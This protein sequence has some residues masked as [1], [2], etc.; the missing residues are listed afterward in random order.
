MQGRARFNYLHNFVYAGETTG[1][2][3]K[4]IFRYVLWLF[5]VAAWPHERAKAQS[6]GAGPSD[7]WGPRPEMVRHPFSEEDRKRFLE[8]PSLY[9]PETWFHFI[10]GNVSKAGITADLEAIREAGIRGIQLFHG[11]FGGEWPGVSPQVK[12][13]TAPWDDMIHHVAQEC[14]R[15]DLRFTMQNCPG[16][17]MAGG[18]WITPENAMRHLV[19]SRTD[20]QGGS[21]QT[22]VLPPPLSGG[23]P[24]RDYREVAVIA[25]PTP[26]GDSVTPLIPRSVTSNLDHLPWE[27]NLGSPEGAKIVLKG[28]EGPVWVEMDFGSEITLRR[29]QFPSI[30]SFNHSWCYEPGVTVKIEAILPQKVAEV[31]RM[32]LPQS[33]W[34]DN[35]PFTMACAEVP[36]RK[37]RIT[38]DNL[39]DMIFS[40]I[41]CFTGARMNNWEAQAGWTLR[42]LDRGSYPEQS[43]NTW[44]DPREV[45]NLT[46]RMD[47]K[48][49]LSW[50]VPAGQWTVMRVGHVNTGKKNG[51]AP[52]EATGWEC[53][54]LSPEGA[55]AH[56]AGYIGRLS[57]HDGPVGNGLMQ[58]MLL[59][60]WE[61]ETQTWTEGMDARFQELRGYSLWSW[62]PALMGYTVGAPE[63]T[64]RFLRDWRATLNDLLVKNFYGRMV[65]LGHQNGLAV[66]YETASGDVFPADILEY[67]KYADVPMC[68]FWH[69]RSEGY[70]GSMNF[71]PIK[72]A[73]SAARLYGKPRLAAE[74]FTSFN[75]TYHESPAMLRHIA[76]IHFAEGVSHL[77]FHTYTH[78]P[79]TDWL[80]P[81][82]SFGSGIGTPFLRGQTWWRYMKSFTTSL[83]RCTY[84]LER[85]Q[86]V[87]DVLW[88]LGDELDHKPLQDAPFPEGYH[89]DYCNTDVLLNR[90]SV[91]D[92]WIVTPEGIRYRLLWLKDSPRLLTE[93]LEK[94]KTMLEQG[95]T[96]VG[97][98]PRGM[99]TLTGGKKAAERYKKLVSHL[100][101]TD[102]RPGVRNIGKGHLISGVSLEAALLQSGV[103][104]DVQGNGLLWTHRG[105]GDADWYFVTSS[106]EEGYSGMP[107]FRAAGTVEIWDPVTG[108]M[109]LAQ[110]VREEKGFTGVP[111]ELPPSGAC[112]ILFRQGE[113]PGGPTGSGSTATRVV[114][115]MAIEGPWT[116]SFPSGWDA[117][118]SLPL[119]ELKPWTMLDLPP[120][121]KSFSGT[122][123][124]S[125]AFTLPA[126]LSG[127]T[128]QLDLGEVGVAATIL[129]NGR[130][131]G[132]VWTPPY[133]VDISRWAQP[134]VNQLS[135][136][137]T[138]TWFNRLVYDDSLPVE[139]RRTWTISGPK[140]GSPLKPSGL[141]GPVTLRITSAIKE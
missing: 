16:W 52:P 126:S 66:A 112:F 56:F 22:I 3:T 40:W 1:P 46:S 65:E 2:M 107:V 29:V 134:G 28:G 13:L 137:V 50:K 70:V 41:R 21:G 122:A 117:P 20:V 36:A 64:T 105:A 68:E 60:S 26:E 79:R 53:N 94:L 55:E 39:H 12:C 15:L 86:P 103:E 111:L 110:R 32:D 58:G 119:K 30:Q 62:F 45:R 84:L 106:S 17:A 81:G 74:A 116:L 31:A 98:P 18:P 37:Y 47:E 138:N 63:T 129:V 61:C 49:H 8:P 10:G 88:Y 101:G 33:N 97:D 67:Y 91:H 124:Y 123:V 43:A 6:A 83:A 54:K 115:E 140:K 44:I 96:I 133:V 95:A 141:Q 59:D 102:H 92:G 121:A 125:A 57:G 99:A 69:P 118:A 51:P 114:R 23:E 82:T 135:V 5:V 78:N 42:G 76:N 108:E 73:A 71:K 93:T 109:A 90:L 19:W 25:F 89:Y 9:H 80:P 113:K 72:P 130:E 87:S 4:N 77:V 127:T 38:I 11:Q 100:W 132:Q 27:K 75:L 139:E 7:G 35:Q 136:E 34:Q 24:W 120:A 48:G 131:A 104:P 128:L 14:R 85:G